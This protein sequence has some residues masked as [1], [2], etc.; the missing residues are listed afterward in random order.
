[1]VIHATTILDVHVLVSWLMSPF[2]VTFGF[3]LYDTHQ[4][5]KEK[6]AI[7][8]FLRIFWILCASTDLFGVRATTGPYPCASLSFGNPNHQCPNPDPHPFALF[9]E[10][11]EIH[12][13]SMFMIASRTPTPRESAMGPNTKSALITRSKFCRQAA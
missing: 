12:H 11:R 4:N 7:L 10:S 9:C 5:N 3:A 6:S 8:F 2:F 13:P 1:M